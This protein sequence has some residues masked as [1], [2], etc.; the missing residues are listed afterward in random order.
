MRSPLYGS[1]SSA[2]KRLLPAKYYDPD[3][4]RDPLG[5]P[6]VVNAPDIP[7]PL[8]VAKEFLIVQNTP[9]TVKKITSHFLT[10]WG[11]F[12]DHDFTLAPESEWADQCRL[13][14]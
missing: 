2:F 1:A 8:K 7:C 4:L 12:L 11:Q 10:Q 14:P 9:T 6:D 5:S 13:A 3:G